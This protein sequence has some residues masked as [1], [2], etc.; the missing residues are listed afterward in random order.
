MVARTLELAFG[1][2]HVTEGR[3]TPHVE[4]PNPRQSP[5]KGRDSLLKTRNPRAQ[6][7]LNE[8]LR[9]R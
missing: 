1:P 4:Q 8:S 7:Y 5:L 3:H 2:H 6:E 9:I